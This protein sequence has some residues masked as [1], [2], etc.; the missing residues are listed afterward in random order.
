[1][2]SNKKSML[3]IT[4]LAVICFGLYG[5]SFHTSLV[6]TLTFN[7]SDIDMMR[8]AYLSDNITFY[9]NNT[10]ELVIKEYMNRSDARF[11]ARATQTGT[12]LDIQH[13]DRPWL[14]TLISNVEIFLPKNYKGTLNVLTVSGKITA[15]SDIDVKD[16]ETSS[17]SGA[18]VLQ[19]VRAEKI[20]LHT[21]S[22]RI[23]ADNLKANSN[24]IKTT[25]GAIQTNQILGS[26]YIKTNSGS[27]NINS[28]AGKKIELI[29]T[30]GAIEAGGLKADVIKAKSTSGRIAIHKSA[31]KLSANSTS[32]RIMVNRATGAANLSSIS[33]AIQ[34]NYEDVSGDIFLKSTSGRVNLT[35]PDDLSFFFDASTTSGA[36]RTSFS[37]GNTQSHKTISRQVGTMPDISI[38]INTTSGSIEVLGRPALKEKVLEKSYIL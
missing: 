2:N 33:G 25:S 14:G 30:S 8:I 21:T 32:G 22:G 18:I 26:T 10:D 12:T 4:A 36:I 23:Q 37:D 7:T 34:A 31:G 20:N 28:V 35:I 1:M 27:I 5:F 6:N 9:E 24:N 19:H 17:T 15:L 38:E 3:Y 13:G 29:S 11:H 16:F